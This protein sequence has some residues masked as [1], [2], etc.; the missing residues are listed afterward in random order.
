MLQVLIAANYFSFPFF[1]DSINPFS[2]IFVFSGCR[3]IIFV[4]DLVSHC[5]YYLPK[6]DSKINK[7][8]DQNCSMTKKISTRAT[9]VRP[10]LSHIGAFDRHFVSVSFGEDMRSGV[11]FTET[12]FTS[13]SFSTDDL[14]KRIHIWIQDFSYFDSH[15]NITNKKTSQQ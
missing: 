14:V 15:W 11:A 6:A 13:F 9:F 4:G 1:P 7:S 10:Y 3:D 5:Y 8:A 12:D 2:F